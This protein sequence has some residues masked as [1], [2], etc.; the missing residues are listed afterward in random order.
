[1]K[2]REIIWLDDVVDK[3]RWKHHVTA[4]EVE[5]V[6]SRKPRINFMEK[7]KHDSDENLYVA[8][9]TTEAGRYLLVLFVLKS[10]QRALIITARDMT[11]SEKQ[12]YEKNKP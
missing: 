9:G 6:L 2:I 7:G 12:Y 4:T 10:N 1:L 5:E 3:L 8:L 11:I